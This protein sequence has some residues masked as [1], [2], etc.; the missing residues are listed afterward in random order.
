[1]RDLPM[2]G[3]PTNPTPSLDEALH[4]I[5]FAGVAGVM[6]V[7]FWRWEDLWMGVARRRC[8][9][10]VVMVRFAVVVG[11]LVAAAFFAAWRCIDGVLCYMVLN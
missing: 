11:F 5:L 10:C 4:I 3:R 1:M 6:T 7:A 9:R 2:L 8:W